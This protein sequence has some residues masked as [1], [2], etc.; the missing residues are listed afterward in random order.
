MAVDRRFSPEWRLVHF[1]KSSNEK[2][3]QQSWVAHLRGLDPRAKLIIV[4]TFLTSVALFMSIPFLSVILLDFP[5]MTPAKVGFIIGISHLCSVV[6]GFVGGGVADY[7]G[8]GRV[9]AVSLLGLVLVFAGFAVAR[10]PLHFFILNGL[11]GFCQALFRPASEAFVSDVTRPEERARVFGYRYA[12]GNIGYTISPALGALLTQVGR[13]AAFGVSAV[14]FLAYWLIF[15]AVVL[16]DGRSVAGGKRSVP[17]GAAVA[18]LRRDSLMV[19]H[20]VGG[21]LVTLV[22][23]Q[24]SS[25]FAQFAKLEIHNGVWLYSAVLTVNTGLVLVLQ[26]IMTR[27][28]KQLGPLKQILTGCVLYAFGFALM[29]MAKLMPGMALAGIVIITAGEVIIVPTGS[30]LID[31]LAPTE[32]KAAYFGAGQLRM[33]GMFLGPIVGGF[34]Y[35]RLGGTSTFLAIAGLS[36]CAALIYTYGVRV[37]A[38]L[39]VSRSETRPETNATRVAR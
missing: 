19:I 7:I 14:I 22:F 35:E 39:T 36:A 4:G 18:I 2:E 37:A 21:I 1:M 9:L 38:A 27:F 32:L 10:A 29:G 3:V 25:T 30:T 23:A 26:P 13:G 6:F 20:I 5:G 17:F 33:A 15:E 8:R 11:N 28:T 24:I 34:M 12:A 16:R 31:S